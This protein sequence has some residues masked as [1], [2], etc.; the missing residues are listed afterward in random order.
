MPIVDDVIDESHEQDFVIT[1]DIINATNVSRV[2]LPK[3]D[4]LCKIVDDDG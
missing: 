2:S 4:S 3:Q 1:L